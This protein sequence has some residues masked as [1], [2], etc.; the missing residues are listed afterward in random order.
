VLSVQGVTKSYRDLPALR[1]IDLQVGAGEILGLVGPNGAGKTTLVSIVAGLRRP[2]SGSLT[3]NGIDV[4]RRPYEAR[5]LIGLAPQELSLYK[6]VTVRENLEVFGRLY[7]LHSGAL[8]D[9][10]YELAERLDFTQTLDRKPTRLSGGEKRRVHTAIALLHRPSLLLL[11]EPTAGC[12]VATRVVILDLIRE[13][14]DEGSAVL[15]CTHYLAEVE[16]L[17]ASIAILDRGEIIARGA[18]NDLLAA[19]DVTAVEL[20]FDGAIPDIAF[21]GVDASRDGSLIRI[22]TRDPA[23]TTVQALSAIG[24][25]ADRLLAVE[26]VKPSLEGVYLRLTGRRYPRPEASHNGDSSDAQ[27]DTAA[28]PPK[29]DVLTGGGNS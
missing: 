22:A 12:D 16:A 8:R 28:A 21:D 5:E 1:D 14:R 20:A 9:R 15:Y 19:H 4:V 13:L 29:A 24:A 25:A 17:E 11:D 27:L 26:I 6:K 3:I 2:D 18:L 7:G 10:I 23:R